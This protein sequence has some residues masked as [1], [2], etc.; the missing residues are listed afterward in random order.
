MPVRQILPGI[1]VICIFLAMLL[2]PEAVFN[3]AF[4][5]L[6][7]WFQVIFPTLF[8]F[9]LISGLM[10]SSGGLSIV[11]RLLGGVSRTV[12]RTSENG[13]FAVLAGFL[14]GYAPFPLH[15]PPQYKDNGSEASAPGSGP[16]HLQSSNSPVPET[17]P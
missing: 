9:M 16:D 11:S 10:L 7:L 6:M 3:G 4:D 2:S 1:T 15:Y 14:C 13:S 17:V 5:G 8:P 12:F